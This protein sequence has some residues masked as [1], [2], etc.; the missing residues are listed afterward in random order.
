[1]YLALAPEPCYLRRWDVADPLRVLEAH[2]PAQTPLLLLL[3]SLRRGLLLL[4]L[5]LR[6]RPEIEP[7]ELRLPVSLEGGTVLPADH[8]GVAAEQGVE[9]PGNY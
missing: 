6:R 5:L 8:E 2:G 3:L 7:G 1:M 9:A 4:L